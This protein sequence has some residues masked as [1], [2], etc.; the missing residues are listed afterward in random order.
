LFDLV[1]VQHIVDIAVTVVLLRSFWINNP[2]VIDHEFVQ[3]FLV[4]LFQLDI[5][6]PDIAHLVQLDTLAPVVEGS[7]DVNVVGLGMG[8]ASINASAMNGLERVS[9]QGR[10]AWTY[11][12]NRKLPMSSTSF[13][14]ASQ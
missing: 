4:G 8:P 6:F 3:N 1:R 2:L 14:G 9:P 13:S 7:C 12:L 10:G 11:H 5:L